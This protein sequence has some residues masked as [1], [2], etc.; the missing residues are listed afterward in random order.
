MFAFLGLG[1]QEIIILAALGGVLAG[2]ALAVVLTVIRVSK[3]SSAREAALE[4]ENRRL[5]AELDQNPPPPP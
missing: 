1:V 4:D 5:R 3:D 2:V